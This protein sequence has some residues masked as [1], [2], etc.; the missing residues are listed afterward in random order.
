[1][2]L[3]LSDGN[4]KIKTQANQYNKKIAVFDMLAGLTCPVALQCKASVLVR[5][6]DINQRFILDEHIAYKCFA[7]KA[8]SQYFWTFLNLARLIRL[9]FQ[10]LH[11]R[12][13]HGDLNEFNQRIR[14]DSH[15]SGVVTFSQEVFY[16]IGRYVC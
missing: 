1:M 2:V 14:Y 8:E 11:K 4:G 10:S 15:S 7:V 12:N 16:R 3:K 9:S 5:N 13:L 6:G